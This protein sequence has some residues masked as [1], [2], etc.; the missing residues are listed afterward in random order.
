MTKGELIDSVLI[1]INGGDLSDDNDFRREDVEVLIGPA[2]AKA[3]T[4]QQRIDRQERL[5]EIR[6]LGGAR[7]DDKQFLVTLNYTPAKH[8]Q[9]TDLYYIDLPFRIQSI[10]GEGLEDLFPAVGNASY[11]RVASRRQ[12]IGIPETGLQATFFWHEIGP[13]RMSEIYML[14]LGEPVCSHYI[15]V[16][17]DPSQQSDDEELLIPAGM[18]MDIITMIKN[19]FLQL[20]EIPGEEENDDRQDF[21]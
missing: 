16:A 4:D 5:R 6:L 17:I 13:D 8:P 18:E 19:H 20:I 9:R 21:E 11:I 2:I 7:V 10:G 12:V 15:R 14:N 1:A 3:V